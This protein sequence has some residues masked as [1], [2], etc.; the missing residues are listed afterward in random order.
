MVFGEAIHSRAVERPHLESEL[1]QAVEREEFILECQPIVSLLD[2]LHH[3]GVRL[4]MDDFGQDARGQ[5]RSEH[6]KNNYQPAHNLRMNV[7]AEGAET[8]EQIRQLNGMN[9]DCV[10][11]YFSPRRF[12]LEN[13]NAYWKSSIPPGTAGVSAA[14]Q[15]QSA[16]FQDSTARFVVRRIA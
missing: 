6:R 13:L 11:G 3:L 8:A 2:E 4:S 1:R 10:E 16:E 12:K 5:T 9:C 14:C 15:S 7:I